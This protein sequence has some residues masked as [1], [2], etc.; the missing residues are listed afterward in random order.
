ME[1]FLESKIVFCLQVLRAS[2]VISWDSGLATK[3]K[4]ELCAVGPSSNLYLVS[5]LN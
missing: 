2:I 3:K 4:M 5:S 1:A